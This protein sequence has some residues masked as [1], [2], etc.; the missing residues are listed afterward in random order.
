MLKNKSGKIWGWGLGGRGEGGTVAAAQG[1]VGHSLVGSEQL[2]C[3][4]L[5]LYIYITVLFFPL[6]FLSY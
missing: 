5:V 3:T 4:S 6:L 1:L 2:H